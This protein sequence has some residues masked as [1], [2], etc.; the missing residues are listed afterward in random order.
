M[1]AKPSSLEFFARLRWLDGRPLLSTI[2]EYRKSIFVQALDQRRPD[3]S[4]AYNLVLCGRAKK[5]FKT[6]DMILAAIYVLMVRDDS[7]QSATCYIV[8]SDE[9]QASDGLALAKAIVAANPELEAELEVRV[10]EILRRDGRGTLRILPA[11]NVAG[12]HGKTFAFCGI[13]EAHTMKNWDVLEAMAQDPTRP[14]LTWI[15]SYDALDS[16]AGMPLYD[17]KAIGMEGSDSRMLFSWYSADYTTDPTFAQVEPELRANPSMGS[18]PEGRAYLETWRRRLPS[19]RFKRLH[20][21]LPVS[22]EAAFVE[23]SDWD[24]LVDPNWRPPQHDP[25]MPI[26]TGVD[27][28]IKHDCTAIVAATW[29]KET[30]RLKLVSSEIFH[31][32]TDGPVDINSLVPYQIGLLRKR[33]Q[34]RQVLYD[35]Y[36]M[37]S[38]A[39]RL[40]ALGIPMQEFPQTMQNLT[41][42][43]TSLYNLIKH[44]L[45]VVRPD[46]EMRHAVTRAAVVEVGRGWK[47]TKNAQGDKIDSVVALS[48]ACLGAVT[49]GETVE[50]EMQFQS[51]VIVT[52]HKDTG[53]VTVF[54]GPQ[55]TQGPPSHYL[56]QNQGDRPWEAY[57]DQYGVRATK[58]F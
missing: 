27:I 52:Q 16:V 45:L 17:L 8:A 5:N 49:Q 19:N 32:S 15:T 7:P 53:A 56:K 50:Q 14:S 12:M 26:W 29:C 40:N 9:D 28:G 55:D 34:L 37:V 13:D 41:E 54:G 1:A 38:I 23:A 36:Q 39:Q 51:P 30:K 58:L 31:P 6:S 18:W 25:N 21:N 35:P 3:G 43:T 57:I 20:L 33:F 22:S 48:M 24:Q 47:L 44:K 4:P 10:N 11:R 2:E 46:P 42:A